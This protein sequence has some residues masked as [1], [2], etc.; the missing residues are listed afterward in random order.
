MK[1]VAIA[2]GAHPDDIEFYMAGTLLLLKNAGWETH[3]MN[4]ANGCNGSVQYNANKTRIIRRGEARR[5]AK[6]L[7]AHFHESLCNDL[8]I[9]YDLKLLRRLAAVIREVK[10]NIVLTHSPVDYMEDHTNTSRL[11]VTA[12]FTHA[13][14]NFRS[15]PPR[16]VADYDVTIYHATPHSLRGPL[17]EIITPGAF[18]NTESVQATKRAALAEHKSQQNWLDVSQGMDSLGDKVDDMA[19]VVGRLSRK[20]KFAEGWRRHLHYGFSATEVDPLREALGK[21]YL[22]NKDYEEGLAEIAE[23]Q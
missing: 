6:V 5:A 11:A 15:T 8:E 4:V 17:R 2:I 13:M 9:F 19:R 16:P 7:G 22:V 10:P 12:A 20:F 23:R 3:Y 18:V 14:P 1:S 21:H